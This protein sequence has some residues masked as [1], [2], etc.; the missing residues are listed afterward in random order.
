ML[1]GLSKE[2][3]RQVILLALDV[4]HFLAKDD[5]MLAAAL[6]EDANMPI[7]IYIAFWS[8]LNSEQRSIIKGVQGM[9]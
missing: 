9:K 6:I 8:L 4:T 1:D 5:V 3:T 7:E 2:Q